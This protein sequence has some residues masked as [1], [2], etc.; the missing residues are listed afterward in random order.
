MTTQPH[1]NYYAH[2]S[3]AKHD[4]AGGDRHGDTPVGITAWRT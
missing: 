3:Q 2:D 4:A 1:A